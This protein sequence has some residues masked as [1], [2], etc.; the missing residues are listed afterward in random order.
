[1]LWQEAAA[2]ESLSSSSSSD[3][4]NVT[5]PEEL[6]QNERFGILSHGTQQDPIYN[7]GNKASLLLFD[8]TLENLCQTPSRYS[9]VESLM[10]DREQLIQQIA[11]VG[12]GTITNA[13]RT[14]T[15]GKLFVMET[16]WIWHVHHPNNGQRIGLAA[17]YDRSKV[18]DYTGPPP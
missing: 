5:S 12:Y 1:M 7:Y 17:L 14:T 16:I 13:L 2:A 10:Q 9:T 18:K 6:D 15:R 4:Q 3:L 8:E 11:D